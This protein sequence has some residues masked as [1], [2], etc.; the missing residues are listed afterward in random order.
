MVWRGGWGLRR[1]QRALEGQRGV[2][3]GHVHGAGLCLKVVHTRR[4]WCV[5][6]RRAGV[7]GDGTGA[8]RSTFSTVRCVALPMTCAR[9]T[10]MLRQ[11]IV[12]FRRCPDLMGFGV[13]LY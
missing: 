5:T 7:S 3:Y 8:H 1:A 13:R 4:R 9:D 10:T 6:F 11:W 2:G 12:I